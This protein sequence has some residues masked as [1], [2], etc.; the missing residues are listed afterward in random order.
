MPRGSPSPTLE[1][2]DFGDG[3]RLRALAAGDEYQIGRFR[4]P[5]FPFVHQVRAVGLLESCIAL[6]G[7]SAWLLTFIVTRVTIAPPTPPSAAS[8]DETVEHGALFP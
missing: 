8:Q 1:R 3:A 2:G 4:H 6:R 5:L 7:T